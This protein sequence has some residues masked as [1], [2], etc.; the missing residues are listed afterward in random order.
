MS[1]IE[2]LRYVRLGVVDPEATADFAT[3]VVGLQK[4][5]APDGVAMFRSDDRDH[6][7]VVQSLADAKAPEILALELRSPD[8]LTKMCNKLSAAGYVVTDGTAEECE[9]RRCK[10]M[11]HF[12]IRAGVRIE[13]LVRPQN[14]GW[15]YF[16][17]RD[18]GITEFFG[19]AFA[20]TDIEAD[21][22]L[23]IDLFGGKVAD[24]LGDAVYIAIDDEHHR[25][26]IYPSDRDG[27]LEMQ[28][29]VE[30]LH[31]L[32]QNSYFLQSAQVP[33]AHGPGRRSVSEQVFL[34][35]KSPDQMLFGLVT[36]G[37]QHPFNEP[38][39]PR[40]FPR[41]SNSFCNW[42]SVSEIPEYSA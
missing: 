24:Y 36:E 6:A 13:M 27:I 32:M 23:W 9:Q 8:L 29:R 33:I 7:L 12:R 41:H 17:S 35:Y 21:T 18:A 26:A 39:T 14:S 25:I 16:G 15:R 22:K 28:F 10:Q 5:E 11:A 19:I 30:G 31:Q 3:R 20:S 1:L 38:R 4:I 34:S 37:A 40:Q 42:G 2:K